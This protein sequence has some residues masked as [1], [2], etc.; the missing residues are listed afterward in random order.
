[1]KKMDSTATGSWTP[2][3]NPASSAAKNSCHPNLKVLYFMEKGTHA[4][5]DGIIYKRTV[6]RTSASMFQPDS[7]HVCQF[8]SHLTG[9]KEIHEYL[10]KYW[11]H[12]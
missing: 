9:I 12:V 5:G 11:D 7:L 1:M 10:C 8:Q 2:D 6:I 4:S 3:N